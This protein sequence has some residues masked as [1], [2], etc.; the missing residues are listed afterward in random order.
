MCPTINKLIPCG[1]RAR[2]CAGRGSQCFRS[3][4]W[5]GGT[6]SAHSFEAI[7]ESFCRSTDGIQP[8]MRS[9]FSLMFA[10]SRHLNFRLARDSARI[11][12]RNEIGDGP[13]SYQ[14]K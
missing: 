3:N 9:T 8:D 7:W 1:V 6:P 2:G 11:D 12:L 5:A 14:Q 10:Q 13:P 4:P